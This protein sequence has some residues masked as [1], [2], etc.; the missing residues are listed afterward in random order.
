MLFIFGP[1]G[2][3]LQLEFWFLGPYKWLRI[4][5]FKILTIGCLNLLVDMAQLSA[6]GPNH[7]DT[8]QN[9]VDL[10]IVVKN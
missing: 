5:I 1:F 7:C 4:P 9:T 8:G 6:G 10:S 3:Y 2:W